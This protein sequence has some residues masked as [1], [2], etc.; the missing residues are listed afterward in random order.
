M[1]RTRV[2]LDR[3]EKEAQILEAAERRLVE[4]GYGAL[5]VV[6]LARELGLAQNAVY[7][8]FPSTD[9]LFVAALERMMR[10]IAA[11]KPPRHGSPDR[12]VMWFVDQLAELEHVRAAMYERAR[13]SD[14]VAAFVSELNATW[15]RMLAGALAD[16]I[17]EA[18]REL[19]VDA[20]LATIQGALFQGLA[21][22]E[23]RRLIGYALERLA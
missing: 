9:H 14:V 2:E 18:D 5:S 1:A 23:R 15:R 19:A 13:E 16:R 4:G 10:G 3:G 11:R 20:L 17:A 6:G 8:Y 7:W 12:Q 22:A 21:P